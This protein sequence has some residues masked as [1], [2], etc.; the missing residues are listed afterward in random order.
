MTQPKLVIVDTCVL[1]PATTRSDSPEKR[2]FDKLVRDKRVVM[3]GVIAAEVLRGY[4][5]EGEAGYAGSRLRKLPRTEVMWEDW[6]EAGRLGRFTAA[7]G[8]DLPLA[9]LVIAAVALRIGAAVFTTDP[10]FDRIPNLDRF[11]P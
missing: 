7:R 8:A 3:L 11:V 5:T 6:V 9:D 2:Q 10:H 4:R 1:V